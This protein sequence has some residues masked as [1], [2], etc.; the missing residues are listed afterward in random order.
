MD[1]KILDANGDAGKELMVPKYRFDEANQRAQQAELK[2]AE[3]T[4]ALEATKGDKEKI[5]ALEKELADTKAG[6]EAEKSAAKK[7]SAIELAIKDKV[8]DMEVV[9]KL[10]DMDKITIDEEG[11]VQGLDEQVKALQTGKPYLWKPAKQEVKTQQKGKEPAVKSYAQTLAEKKN[12]Q[13]GIVNKSK[14]YF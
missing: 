9:S 11:K 7:Q 6:Y 13:Q 1:E 10:L 8:V 4:S 5:A 14:S 3:L 12:A 2:V